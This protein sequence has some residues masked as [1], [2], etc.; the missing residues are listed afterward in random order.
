[1]R[2]IFAVRPI[3]T[4]P[5]GMHEPPPTAGLVTPAGS[6]LRAAGLARRSLRHSRFGRDRNSCR[7]SSG[8]GNRHTETA[9]LT[10][11]RNVR[12]CRHHVDESHDCRDIGPACVPS[13]VWGTASMQNRQVGLGAVLAPQYRNAS[14]PPP[15]RQAAHA[16][17]GGIAP[18]D[19]P[20]P[21]Q[22]LRTGSSGST[23]LRAVSRQTF[24]QFAPEKRGSGQPSTGSRVS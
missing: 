23:S 22:Q 24:R 20:S 13:T 3:A 18:D 5:I 6:T 2:H 9:G 14:P 21:I 15:P 19:T 12:S 10:Q 8:R 4:R 7:S 16:I 1:M 11:H 17:Q